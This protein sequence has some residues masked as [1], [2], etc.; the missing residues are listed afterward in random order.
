MYIRIA[1][2]IE[3]RLRVSHSLRSLANNFK[4]TLSAKLFNFKFL[5]KNIIM[6]TFRGFILAHKGVTKFPVQLKTLSEG[7]LVAHTKILAGF[8]GKDE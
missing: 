2:S 5:D 7:E 3:L 1:L 4:T 6:S 8:M